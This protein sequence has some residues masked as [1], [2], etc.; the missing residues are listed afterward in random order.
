M[1]GLAAGSRAGAK[2]AEIDP[3]V[4]R[5]DGAARPPLVSSDS[6]RF[7]DVWFSRIRVVGL[8]DD[9]ARAAP[10]YRAAG[11]DPRAAS[12]SSIERAGARRS[13]EPEQRLQEKCSGSRSA[14]NQAPTSG[15]QHRFLLL[16]ALNIKESAAG[17]R[18]TRDG[19]LDAR[20][21]LSAE[22]IC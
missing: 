13:T 21:L 11:H 2:R 16:D 14:A 7:V 8:H 22:Q 4:G 20:L 10:R 15:Q 6:M 17:G 5:H 9:A 18:Q 19:R 1:A 3:R 12:A